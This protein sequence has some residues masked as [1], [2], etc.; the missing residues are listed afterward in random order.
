MSLDNNTP[1]SPLP[2]LDAALKRGGGEIK[3]IEETYV[4]MEQ[5]EHILA[6]PDM[7]IG[8]TTHTT[9]ERWIYESDEKGMVLKN[10]TYAPGLYKIFDEILVNAADNYQRDPS[11]K[12]IKVVINPEENLISVENDG[13]GI[14]VKM[15]E[16]H[17]KYVP[18]L[19]FG[20]LLTGS[21]FDDNVN[22]VTGGRNGLG[23]K[24]ANIYSNEFIVETVQN[25][26]SF[27]QVYHH[28]MKERSAPEIKS[29]RGRDFTR[30]TFK[31]DLNRFNMETLDADIVALM[32]KRVYDI[33]GCNSSLKVSLN[34]NPISVKTFKDYAMMYFKSRSTDRPPELIYE[35]I[36]D[37]DGKRRWEVIFTLSDGEFHQ[38]SFVNSIWT[39]RGG[40]H[41]Q[42]VFKKIADQLAPKIQKKNKGTEV[43]PS[44]IKNHCFI[45][46]NCLIN[47]PSFDSQTKE[48][49]KSTISQW[50]TKCDL[51]DTFFKKVS[52]SG[53]IEQILTWN[54]GRSAQQLKTT[55][56]K[57]QKRIVGIAKLNEANNAGTAKSKNCTLIL[58]EGDS[59]KGLAVAGL[60]VVGR[61][62]YGVFPLR[63]KMLNVRDAPTKTIIENEE[64]NSIVKILGL[65]HEKNYKNSDELRYGHIMIMTDQDHDGSHIKGLLINF[66]HCFWPSLLKVPN[67]ITEFITPIV[68]A[69]KGDQSL[70]FFTIPEYENWKE[71]SNTKGWKVKYYKGLGTSQASEMQEYFSD[72]DKHKKFFKYSGQQDDDSIVLAFSKQYADKRK[73]WLASFEP[74]TYLDQSLVKIPY[75]D[76]INKELILFSL[77]DC[78]RS[79]PS[80]VD[81]FKPGQRKILFSCFKRNLKG[82]IKVAQ[83]SG[84]V[85][86]HSAYHHG[87]ES[88]HST[89]IGMAQNFVGSNNL[90][91]LEPIGGFGTRDMGGKDASAARYVHTTLSVITR[92]IF[93]PSDD[94]I[95]DY[96]LEEGLSIQ[97]VWYMPTVPIVL[98]N[99]SQGIGTGWSSTVPNYNPS[100]IIENLRR[101][102]RNEDLEPMHPWYRGFL[103]SIEYNPPKKNYIVKGHWKRIGD[104]CIEITELPVKKWTQDY[105]EFLENLLL[106]ATEKEKVK[107]MK[108]RKR[109]RGTEKEEPA[110]SKKDAEEP[111]IKDYK[112]YHTNTRVH[113]KVYSDKFYLMTDAEIE[114]R[115]KLVSTIACTNMNLFDHTGKIKRYATPEDILR[116]FYTIRLEYYQKRKDFMVKKIEK[117]WN[118]LDN[119]VRFILAVIKGEIV[120][121]NR[122]RAVLID[123]LEKMG[124]DRIAKEKPRKVQETEI[125]AEGEEKE[126]EDEVTDIKDEKRAS[127]Y[128]YLL[129]MPLWSLTME[130]VE[131]LKKDLEI[132]KEELDAMRATRIEDLWRSDLDGFE[133]AWEVYKNNMDI[134]DAVGVGG[135]AFL[136]KPSGAIKGVDPKKQKQNSDLLKKL[137]KL[138]P[139]TESAKKAK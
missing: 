26:K 103:G 46:V 135:S 84:Y 37:N 119:K 99:G 118:L 18:E 132:K 98:I 101:L 106:D 63:G 43:K 130:R 17:K 16:K 67:F 31:P 19:I 58:L 39:I 8:S 20:D 36:L 51:S 71:T 13:A 61:D 41:V 108:E 137:Q 89:I 65:Q 96:L 129:S 7:Y 109:K 12:Y 90:N 81:G 24:L 121:N 2:V 56:G 50:G 1:S 21:N 112:E 116:E 14:P 29:M 54:Q 25:N 73:E 62:N 83:L 77:A 93:H 127:D 80:L 47:N 70:S 49:L 124:F 75:N 55:S 66:F 100:D 3:T 76:F 114:K 48:T 34:N 5:H 59:A 87:E 113:F 74:G 78:E 105:K 53:V 9:E 22:K 122:K 139:N 10:I 91:M 117:D 134:L 45:F 72:L 97:P 32:T 38:V 15:H 138:A 52:L 120:V 85:S 11:M 88:L 126:N 40:T 104:D 30:I 60:S 136:G 133:H 64:I 68:K 79:I 111:L 92:Y 33:A 4:K 128:D 115:F 131:K 6:R 44:Q 102:L 95:L 27:R 35:K 125:L 107:K 69:T 42:T 28:N 86:E 57:K 82:E 123:E 110:P 23:A 94:G